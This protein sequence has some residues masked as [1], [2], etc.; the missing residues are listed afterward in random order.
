MFPGT[1][2]GKNKAYSKQMSGKSRK[3]TCTKK[4]AINAGLAKINKCPLFNAVLC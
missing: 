3:W 1:H 2:G 4:K